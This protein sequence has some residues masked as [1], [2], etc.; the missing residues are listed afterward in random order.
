MSIL[1][2]FFGRFFWHHLKSQRFSVLFWR[3][4]TEVTTFPPLCSRDLRQEL[5]AGVNFRDLSWARASRGGSVRSVGCCPHWTAFTE[6]GSGWTAQNSRSR[7]KSSQQPLRGLCVFVRRVEYKPH[8][9]LYRAVLLALIHTD[10]RAHVEFSCD[11]V[12]FRGGCELDR[13][14]RPG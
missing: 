13:P 10:V 4:R 7:R 3:L 11:D 1:I 5:L 9:K 6:G 12:S 2:V 14:H 8:S